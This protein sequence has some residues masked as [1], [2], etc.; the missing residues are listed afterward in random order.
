MKIKLAYGKEGLDITL[1]DYLNVD[2]VE[3]KYT[4]GLPDQAAAIE[5]SLLRPIDSKPLRDLL[6]Q[7]DTVGI[8]VNDITR[9]TP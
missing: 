5:D 4:E 9:P 6:K 2:I 8:V 3:P 7:S 1:P